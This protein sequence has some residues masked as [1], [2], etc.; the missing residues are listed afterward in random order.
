MNQLSTATTGST[1]QAHIIAYLEEHFEE[2]QQILCP[3]WQ[4]YDRSQHEISP[5]NAVRPDRVPSLSTKKACTLTSREREIL[6]LVA[7]GLT[8]IRVAALLF[9][10]PRTV[11]THLISIYSKLGITGDEDINQRVMATRYALEHHLA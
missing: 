1:E 5:H 3:G 10:S 8:D 11:N 7:M 9:I 4:P 6:Q 2:L